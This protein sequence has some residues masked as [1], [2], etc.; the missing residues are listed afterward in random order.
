MS[1]NNWSLQNFSSF[2][3]AIL[4]TLCFGFTS[5]SMFCVECRL[6]RIVKRLQNAGDW[7]PI[8][9][10][11]SPLSSLVSTPSLLSPLCPVCLQTKHNKYNIAPLVLFEIFIP[12]GFWFLTSASVGQ[13]LTNLCSLFWI[14]FQNVIPARAVSR[15]CSVFSSSNSDTKEEALCVR[16]LGNLSKITP[17]IFLSH[18]VSKIWGKFQSL[19]N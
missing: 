11:S 6:D 17:T 4:Y 15:T 8:K 1:K 7:W 13:Y 2:I 18:H 12:H 5:M 16:G 3:K 10:C 9:C 14:K 19:P